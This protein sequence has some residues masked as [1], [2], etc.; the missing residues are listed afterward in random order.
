M[1]NGMKDKVVKV[2]ALYCSSTDIEL[3]EKERRTRRRHLM[4]QRKKSP[5]KEGRASTQKTRKQAKSS[6][7]LPSREAG[8]K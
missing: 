8:N 6:A 2:K 5:C 3:R 7:V 4:K 1:R